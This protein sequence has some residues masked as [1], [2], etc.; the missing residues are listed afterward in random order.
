MAH[1]AG[2]SHVI[3]VLVSS[4]P[5]FRIS[6]FLNGVPL[7]VG[8]NDE[9]FSVIHGVGEGE[10]LEGEIQ[11]LKDNG[12]PLGWRESSPIDAELHPTVC[13][14]P[15]VRVLS[16]SHLAPARDGSGTQMH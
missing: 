8:E 13:L 3:G 7:V 16:S 11:M 4:K 2:E 9:E 1:H 5:S 14:T 12:S 15:G 10:K 6:F